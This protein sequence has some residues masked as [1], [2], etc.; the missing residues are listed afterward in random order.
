VIAAA[1]VEENRRNCS[2]PLDEGEVRAI[3]NSIGRYDPASALLTAPMTDLGNAERLVETSGEDFRYFVE[4]DKWVAWDGRRWV[5]DKGGAIVRAAGQV[6]RRTAQAAD[7]AGDA[8]LFKFARRSE[9]AGKLSAMV[10]LAQSVASVQV[11]GGDLDANPDLLNFRNGTVDL[12]TGELR[13]HRREDLITKLCPVDYDEGAAC[14]AWMSFVDRVMDGNTNLI[15][16]I[17]RAIGYSLTGSTSEQVLFLLHGTG[18]NGKSTLLEV[19]RAF[20]GDYATQSDF[21][22]FLERRSDGVRNDIARLAGARLVSAIEADEGRRLAESVLKQVTGGDVVTARFLFAEFF[23]FKPA[24]KLWLAAN[25]K[26]SFKG[27]DYAM[28]RRVRLIPFGVTIPPGERDPRLVE[29]LC[30]ELPGIAR[31]AVEGSLAWRSGGLSAPPE[32]IAATDQYTSDMDVIGRFLEERC[33]T[34]PSKRERTSVVY[35]AFRLWAEEAGEASPMS[36]LEFSA[37]LESRGFRRTR[38]NGKRWTLGL[39]MRQ[40]DDDGPPS[41]GSA[42]LGATD[43]EF[44]F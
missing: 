36:Q 28:A 3:A 12:T 14:P 21:T 19:V 35:A 6:A 4:R 9:A 26:P 7:D 41:A 16:F 27:D 38:S 11:A 22:T 5:L 40:R 13:P 44:S 33:Q 30:K 39:S 8:K 43:A 37:R 32:V 24:F 2:P 29:K 1:L 42:A 23:E 18:A 20:L 17:R 10:K 15:E 31:W 34:V 25:H